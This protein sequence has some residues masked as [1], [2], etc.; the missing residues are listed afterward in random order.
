MGLEKKCG[1][2]KKEGWG[3]RESVFGLQDLAEACS[4]RRREIRKAREKGE[5]KVHS[6]VHRNRN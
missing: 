6:V 3:R 4:E 2:G 5:T 1:S